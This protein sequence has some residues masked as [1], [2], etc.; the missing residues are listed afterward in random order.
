MGESDSEGLISWIDAYPQAQ[1]IG[2][3]A[4][5]YGYTLEQI[6]QLSLFQFEFLVD[7]VKWATK[8]PRAQT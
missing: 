5:H 1:K 6:S 8:Q 4:Y 7:W 2:F 3:I